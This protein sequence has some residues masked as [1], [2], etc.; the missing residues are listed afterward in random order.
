MNK[1]ML[2][3]IAYT[4]GRAAIAAVIALYMSGISDPKVLLNAFIASLLAPILKA[5]DPKEKLYGI[6]S[7]NGQG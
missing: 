2:Q 6:G 4:Y 3:A 7:G 5:L 1:E